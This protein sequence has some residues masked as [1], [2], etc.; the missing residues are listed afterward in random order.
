MWKS[1][2]ITIS[3]KLV[4]NLKLKFVHQFG[5]ACLRGESGFEF[6]AMGHLR[7]HKAINM[8]KKYKFIVSLYTRTYF[9]RYSVN[10]EQTQS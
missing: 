8:S 10:D 6:K 4:V 9:V 5:K 3:V 2:I 1:A 7:Q